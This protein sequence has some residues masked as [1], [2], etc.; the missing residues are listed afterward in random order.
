MERKRSSGFRHIFT[1]AFDRLF[2][3]NF[4]KVNVYDCLAGL[5]NRARMDIAPPH[6]LEIGEKLL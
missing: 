4:G 3:V 5:G 1:V 6:R 2:W